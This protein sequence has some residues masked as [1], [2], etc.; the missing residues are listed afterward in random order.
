MEA[1]RAGLGAG[2]GG[3][4]ERGLL[5]PAPLLRLG[6][7]C[8]QGG[9]ILPGLSAPG[10][11]SEPGLLPARP[12][13]A[14]PGDGRGSHR[15]AGRRVVTIFIFFSFLFVLVKRKKK[16]I[17]QFAADSLEKAF[18]YSL[19]VSPIFL[20]SSCHCVPHQTPLTSLRATRRLVWFF[21]FLLSLPTFLHS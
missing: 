20:F 4:G 16:K 17:N 7:G 12:P 10:A 13:C 3:A 8:R 19:C 18:F 5:C 21:S 15:K 1:G 6:Q 14:G 9:T 11:D 2:L